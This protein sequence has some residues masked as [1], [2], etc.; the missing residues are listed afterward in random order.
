MHILFDYHVIFYTFDGSEKQ[1]YENRL[2]LV[3]GCGLL[4]EVP[5]GA[6]YPG[7]CG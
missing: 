7:K 4:K 3:C 2:K 6:F 1:P 5:M